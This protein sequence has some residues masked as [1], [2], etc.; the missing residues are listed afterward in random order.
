MSRLTALL[1][2]LVMAGAEVAPAAG[3]NSVLARLLP[4]SR[5]GGGQGYNPGTAGYQ[6]HFYFSTATN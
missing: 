6:V 4:W 1:A 5:G 3:Q 2:V